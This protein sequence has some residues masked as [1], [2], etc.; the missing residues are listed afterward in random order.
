MMHHFVQ[1]LLKSKAWITNFLR[2]SA[3]TGKRIKCKTYSKTVS[4]A[5]FS[6]YVRRPSSG[7]SF[8]ASF[9]PSL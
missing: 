7:A 6:V 9:I 2:Q 4:S 5:I 8:I 3:N 1:D